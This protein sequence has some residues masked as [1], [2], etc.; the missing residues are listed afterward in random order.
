MAWTTNLAPMERPDEMNPPPSI[1]V[2]VRGRTQI[3]L[4]FNPA[5]TRANQRADPGPT[6]KTRR[7]VP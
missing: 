3:L 1:W 5:N 7:V 2:P 4:P 6:D